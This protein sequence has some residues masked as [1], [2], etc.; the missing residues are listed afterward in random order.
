MTR[1]KS[2]DNKLLRN[3]QDGEPAPSPKANQL[4]ARAGNL[5]L[6]KG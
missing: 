1:S 4:P 5:R 2:D 3:E 6:F